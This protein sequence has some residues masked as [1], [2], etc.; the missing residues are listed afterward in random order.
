MYTISHSQTEKPT[1]SQPVPARTDQPIRKSE[2]STPLKIPQ[3]PR[4]KD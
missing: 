3:Q 1:P 2:P 4:R